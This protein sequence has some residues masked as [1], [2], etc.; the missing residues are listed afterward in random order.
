MPK[1]EELHIGDMP[2]PAERPRGRIAETPRTRMRFHGSRDASI[3]PGSWQDANRGTRR[4]M[5][6]ARRPLNSGGNAEKNRSYAYGTKGVDVAAQPTRR[7]LFAEFVER[8]PDRVQHSIQQAPGD[9][10]DSW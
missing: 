9:Q 5:L 7:Q 10:C 6:E 8:D 3:Q 1:W 2:R 4:L